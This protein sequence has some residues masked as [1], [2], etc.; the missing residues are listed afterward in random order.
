MS[1]ELIYYVYAYIRKSDGTPYYIGKG[2]GNRAFIEHRNVSTP[3]DKTK[4]VFLETNL[5]NTGA[6]AIE[7]RL[8]RWW[9]KKIEGG[10]LCNITDGGDGATGPK[11]EE[12]KASLR[13]FRGPYG[14]QKNPSKRGPRGKVKTGDQ[15]KPR[16]P[17]SEEA[18]AKMSAAKKGKS[19]RPCSE[20]T[21]AKISAA[22]KGKSQGPKGPMTEAQKAN[23]YGPR[24]PY[25][26]SSSV[27]LM[28]D[29]I[30]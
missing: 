2:K 4:I 6:C 22:K 13:G 29:D 27:N 8:I 28:F 23:R 19:T 1:A 11:S 21:K 25:K 3:K 7:R 24:G 10:V 20:E 12:H 5:T 9:G 14:Q 30:D 16:E 18:K 15:R 17:L 26:K